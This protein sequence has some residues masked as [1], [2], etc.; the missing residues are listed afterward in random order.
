M[1][2]NPGF[3]LIEIVIYSAI[4]AVI[5]VFSI[6]MILITNTAFGKART[7][8]N[9]NGQAVAAMERIIRE[10]RL[11]NDIDTSGST[12]DVHPGV[13]TLN[14]VVSASDSTAT[15][16]KFFLQGNDLMLQEGVSAAVLLTSGVEVTNLIFWDINSASSSSRAT[17]TE[18][19]ITGGVGRFG[20]AAKL[21]GTAV[22]RGSY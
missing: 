8:R 20:S 12:F 17:R 9:V 6:N 11:A 18:L 15:T 4:L 21:Y 1:K 10:V 16:R 2:K 3:S 22:L 19:T 13:L 7:S 14:T 5:T